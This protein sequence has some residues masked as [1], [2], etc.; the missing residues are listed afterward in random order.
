MTEI[1]KA[2]REGYR[3]GLR[4][5]RTADQAW[6]ESQ[7]KFLETE[8]VAQRKIVRE[9]SE[10]LK[11]RIVCDIRP[12]F[13]WM[14]NSAALV[15]RGL[16]TVLGDLAALGYDATWGVFRA[17]DVGAPHRRERIYLLAYP[18]SKGLEGGQQWT[19]SR[20]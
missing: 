17:S 1:E 2:Y 7:T 15:I 8:L 13:M 6:H 18:D 19:K 9:A 5:V 11:A 16:G 10:K 20:L 3:D 12:E 14:E 4:G